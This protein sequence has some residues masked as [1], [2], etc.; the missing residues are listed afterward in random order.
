M[1]CRQWKRAALRSGAVLR[2]RIWKRRLCA[3]CGGMLL[4]VGVFG[5]VAV[6]APAPPKLLAVLLVAYALVRIAWGM[7]RA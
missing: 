3:V 1:S 2:A 4:F 7:A 5:T 6:V